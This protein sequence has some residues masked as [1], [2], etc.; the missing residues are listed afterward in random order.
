MTLA[1]LSGG[2][3]LAVAFRV[4]PLP[5]RSFVLSSY[6]RSVILTEERFLRFQL[7]QDSETMCV[8][9]EKHRRG[10]K[11]SISFLERRCAVAS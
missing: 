11:V 6:V 10:E 9:S 5:L 4:D 8:P 7:R 3:P 1:L 2:F